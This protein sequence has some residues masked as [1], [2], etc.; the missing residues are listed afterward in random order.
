MWHAQLS[1]SWTWTAALTSWIAWKERRPLN[2]SYG[3]LSTQ[4][5]WGRDHCGWLSLVDRDICLT[6]DYCRID[7][8]Q[9]EVDSRW[10]R[11]QQPHRGRVPALPDHSER[12][13]LLWYRARRGVKGRAHCGTAVVSSCDGLLR[14]HWR[15]AVGNTHTRRVILLTSDMKDYMLMINWWTLQ[16]FY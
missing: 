14:L 12:R 16:G 1:I 3:L 2:E 13:T 8:W 5:W 6:Q 10:G 15:L 11:G 7:D 4:Q 9:C